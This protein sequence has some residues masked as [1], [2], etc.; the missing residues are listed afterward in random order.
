MLPIKDGRHTDIDGNVLG[1]RQIKERYMASI[2]EH[3][4]DLPF[5]IVSGK[6]FVS[7][8]VIPRGFLNH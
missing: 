1:V 7:M 4:N 3:G 8:V 5:I 2:K 6:S